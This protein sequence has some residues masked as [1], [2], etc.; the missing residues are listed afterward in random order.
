MSSR[1]NYMPK[2]PAREVTNLMKECTAAAD[3]LAQR[4]RLTPDSEPLPAGID[5]TS[6]EYDAIVEQLKAKSNLPKHAAESVECAFAAKYLER[7]V[8]VLRTLSLEAQPKAI[9]IYIRIISLLGNP[10]D[11]RPSNPYLRNFFTSE[12]H[13]KDLASLIARAIVN[14]VEFT[15]KPGSLSAVCRQLYTIVV[16]GDSSWGDDGRACIDLPLRQAVVEKLKPSMA[17]Q[18][19]EVAK[20]NSTKPKDPI[21]VLVGSLEVA[22]M[23]G[24]GPTY[25][26]ALRHAW[27]TTF[28]SG[29]EGDADCAIK[30]RS[31]ALNHRG[32]RTG[33]TV[34]SG[35]PYG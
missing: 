33:L 34:A 20:G 32:V 25:L 9:S 12:E 35:T 17:P 19:P 15:A 5:F 22:G 28:S 18:D 3:R 16:F 23:D 1:P 8:T 6:D 4:A 31:K 14:G 2:L 24:I 13:A 11:G 29:I 7:L 27:L 26:S 30:R 10:V 21:R